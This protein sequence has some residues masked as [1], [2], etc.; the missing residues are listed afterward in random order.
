MM[1]TWQN[2]N[3]TTRIHHNGDYSG[4]VIIKHR[5]STESEHWFELEIPYEDLKHFVLD[6]IRQDRI[7]AL[8]DLE[9]DRLEEELL[10]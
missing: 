1:H 2:G 5:I 9:Y 4:E 3:N 6:Q 10:R 7:G 8:E